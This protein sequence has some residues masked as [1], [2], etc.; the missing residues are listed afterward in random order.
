MNDIRIEKTREFILPSDELRKN[1]CYLG[2]NFLSKF[3]VDNRLYFR[4]N[5]IAQEDTLFYYEM[6]QY[7]PK[8]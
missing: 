2:R 4:E 1:V 6:E 8:S 7:F 5:M 3:L